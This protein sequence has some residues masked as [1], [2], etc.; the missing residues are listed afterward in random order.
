MVDKRRGERQTAD[1]VKN[2]T[3]QLLG[4]VPKNT[5]EDYILT[6]KNTL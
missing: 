2:D 1:I 3:Q 6:I 4:W 5:I